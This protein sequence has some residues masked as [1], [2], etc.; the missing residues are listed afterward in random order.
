[1]DQMDKLWDLT[2]GAT[3]EGRLVEIVG[4]CYMN[5]FDALRSRLY[6]SQTKPRMTSK[7]IVVYFTIVSKIYDMSGDRCICGHPINW[8]YKCRNI[9]GG[10]LFNVGDECKNQ[11][12]EEDE[13]I[14]ERCKSVEKKS[15]RVHFIQEGISHCQNCVKNTTINRCLQ[16]IPII[17][18]SEKAK[19]RL[20][21]KWMRI[22][23]RRFIIKN[24]KNIKKA[25]INAF[26][27]K[28]VYFRPKTRLSQE[29]FREE[30]EKT[31]EQ[32]KK[33]YKI[34]W[35]GSAW[36]LKPKY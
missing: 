28:I 18:K 26:K 12:K 3:G 17:E 34:K 2:I 24:I 27:G 19:E 11:W 13:S 8:I 10:E 4:K 36:I 6:S 32:W 25:I 22:K 30:L 35:G 15:K 23:I 29:K 21:I 7:E 16:C 9:L 1:M 33:K 14:G 31:K 20:K 5:L